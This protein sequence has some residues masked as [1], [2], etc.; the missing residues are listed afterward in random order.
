MTD[1]FSFCL[2]S[3]L[4]LRLLHQVHAKEP[5]LLGSSK[6]MVPTTNLWPPLPCLSNPLCLYY[7]FIF[8]LIPQA[9]STTQLP[10]TFPQGLQLNN[11]QSLDSD[12]FVAKSN[13][14]VTSKITSTNVKATS[15]QSPK[16]RAVEVKTRRIGAG[17]SGKIRI[18]GT[19]RVSGAVA[20]TPPTID[21][22]ASP[23]AAEP[24]SFLET[25]EN[26][27]TSDLPHQPWRRMSLDTFEGKDS[28]DWHIKTVSNATT[29]ADASFLSHCGDHNMFLGGHCKVGGNH[30]LQKKMT[31]DPTAHTEVRVVAKVHLI[32]SWENEIAWM[33]IDDHV[34]WTTT[35]L[36]AGATTKTNT[37]SLCGNP[38]HSEAS[39]GVVVDVTVPHTT[40][41]VKI[42]FGTSLD[43]HECNESLGLDDVHL[44]VH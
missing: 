24:P 21:L 17:G 40:N 19:L 1:R 15:V 29:T 37:I 42:N 41:T 10:V 30:I 34:V 2:L 43:E 35:G 38:L 36:A 31:L 39:L 16:A 5:I 13:V 32:D 14:A 25:N 33:S 44:Y 12:T 7:P 6:S 28:T 20:Y 23:F 27:A 26:F 9:L 11:E 3:L 4:V 22:A 8:F 18:Q